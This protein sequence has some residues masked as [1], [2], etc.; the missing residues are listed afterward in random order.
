MAPATYRLAAGDA[1]LLMVT[2]LPD[3]PKDDGTQDGEAEERVDRRET[4][5]LRRAPAFARS[6]HAVVTRGEQ[7]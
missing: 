2:P 1:V 4:P 7:G 3:P 5:F 6:V